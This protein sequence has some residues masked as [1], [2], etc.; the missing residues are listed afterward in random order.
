[1]KQSPKPLS[2]KL[3]PET[4]AQDQM[5]RFEFKSSKESALQVSEPVL[6]PVPLV[7]RIYHL[8][9]AYDLHQLVA[10]HPTGSSSLSFLSMQYLNEE[11]AQILKVVNDPAIHH[12]G[13]AL[14]ELITSVRQDTKGSLFVRV[15]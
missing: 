15:P 5:V 1:M 11:L 12:Y 14:T 7:F 13:K 6:V 2:E 8:G 3:K 10:M 4:Y 9:R